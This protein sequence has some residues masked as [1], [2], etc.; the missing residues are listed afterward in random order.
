[1]LKISKCRVTVELT[2]LPHYW[3][4]DCKWR[5]DCGPR[6]NRENFISRLERVTLIN[7]NLYL[8][9]FPAVCLRGPNNDLLYKGIYWDITFWVICYMVMLWWWRNAPVINEKRISSREERPTQLFIICFNYPMILSMLSNRIGSSPK[10]TVVIWTPSVTHVVMVIGFQ[11]FVYHIKFEKNIKLIGKGIE[12]WIL[13]IIS[14][15]DI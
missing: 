12:G 2:C 7:H 4:P 3:L 8:G 10:H 15:K 13:R 6:D 1:M 5:K 9:S 11:P 14:L